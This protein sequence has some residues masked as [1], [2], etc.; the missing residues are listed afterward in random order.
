MGWDYLVEV[1][2]NTLRGN[3]PFDI[4][5]KVPDM[6]IQ[7]KTIWADNHSVD[8]KLI[9][10]ERL[11]RWEYP[12][13]IVI[14]RMKADKTYLDAHVIHLIDGNL[15]RILK[16]LREVEAKN[17]RSIKHR[18]LT[19]NISSGT[20]I[21]TDGDEL[22]KALRDALGDD[23]HNYPVRKRDQL[24]NL[25]F[26][27]HRISGSLEFTAKDNDEALSIFLGMQPA[28]ASRFDA[29]EVRFDIRTPLARDKNI[30]IE[31]KPKSK[32]P[33]QLVISSEH[34]QK[35]AIFNT[36]LYFASLGGPNDPW[37]IL[38]KSNFVELLSSTETEDASF[39]IDIGD[40]QRFTL[41]EWIS[42]TQSSLIMA[43]G[44]SVATIRKQGKALLSYNI[45][46]Q[47][48]LGTSA[49]LKEKFQL[50]S[51]LRELMIELGLRDI[52][53]SDQELL[54]N[55]SAI[56]FVAK[57]QQPS[58]GWVINITSRL[59]VDNALENRDIVEGICAAKM[60]FHGTTIAFWAQMHLNACNESDLLHL[61]CSNLVLRDL[62]V[63]DSHEA[64]ITWVKEA[65]E[66][67]GL[68]VVLRYDK[69]MFKDFYV[70]PSLD[71]EK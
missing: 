22:A 29:D 36:E 47:S 20:A 24:Q 32:G 58:N 54:E 34:E 8:V 4:R 6:K 18:T 16:A 30:L 37:K 68:D 17:A 10:A 26:G 2:I 28:Q 13:F 52:C 42:M 46:Q 27:I 21:A 15:A 40:D 41:D 11:A 19:F 70:T 67:T 51:A 61:K 39:H 14:L 71:Q 38:V 59:L 7:V 69:L 55:W 53:I 3:E 43:L 44:P 5:R 45:K 48:C 33:C 25:G 12:S 57:T 64:F 31:I 60:E 49:S 63:V 66:S 35:R 50:L 65:S 56:C 23:W 1:P 62:A 9:A